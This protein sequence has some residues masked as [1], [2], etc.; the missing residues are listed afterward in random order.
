MLFNH[1][2]ETGLLP[3]TGMYDDIDKSVSFP[4][5]DELQDA[6]FKLH[7]GETVLMLL[8]NNGKSL[9]ATGETDAPET[10]SI[11]DDDVS[12]V[13]QVNAGACDVISENGDT[14]NAWIVPDEQKRELNNVSS[15]ETGR[16]SNSDPTGGTWLLLKT[17]EICRNDKPGVISTRRVY[18][19]KTLRESVA[20]PCGESVR[21]LC[22][23]IDEETGAVQRTGSGD[24]SIPDSGKRITI[25]ETVAADAGI[26]TKNELT[27][28]WLHSEDIASKTSTSSSDAETK[29]ETSKQ[30]RDGEVGEI[31]FSTGEDDNTLDAVEL[32]ETTDTESETMTGVDDR[33]TASNEMPQKGGNAHRFGEGGV[34]ESPEQE[35][36]EQEQSSEKHSE[37][38]PQD[39]DDEQIQNG[40]VEN[41]EHVEI[42]YTPS[43]V[44]VVLLDDDERT[45]EE[46]TGHYMN[47]N[48]ELLCGKTYTTKVKDPE[49]DHYDTVCL[50]CVAAKPGGIKERDI[51]LAIE[52]FV[53][54]TVGEEAPFV[55]SR[56]D[57]ANLLQVLL[58]EN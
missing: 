19:N 27:A 15:D 36:T 46:W 16:D 8:S 22:E 57:A 47:E 53:D 4:V 58:K 5:T 52:E 48:E 31:A 11:S 17:E 12:N 34:E 50:E 54:F 38:T 33:T 18:I 1:V 44:P 20:L 7:A 3:V 23:V 26:G 9:L 40:E 56:E 24:V 49:R 6:Y 45:A 25:P 42:D 43:L 13:V 51:A 14:V 28:I 2:D 29:Q 55:F 21:V 32:D 39:V 35:H 37:S 10:H 30:S 41:E